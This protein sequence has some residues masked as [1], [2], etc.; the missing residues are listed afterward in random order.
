V[1]VRIKIMIH[2]HDMS[3]EAG[4]GPAVKAFLTEAR[5]KDDVQT[6]VLRAEG[7]KLEG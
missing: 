1:T 5:G 4:R 2:T 6:S 7:L 3:A